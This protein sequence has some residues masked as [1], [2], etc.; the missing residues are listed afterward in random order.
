TSPAARFSVGPANGSRV[1]EI[2]EYG[3]IRGYNRNSNAWAQIDFEASKNKEIHCL[4]RLQ[5]IS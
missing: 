4:I 5:K 1:I 3:V 2:E